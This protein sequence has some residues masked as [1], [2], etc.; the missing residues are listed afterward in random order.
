MK[1]YKV[2]MLGGSFNP[3]H[4][5]HVKSIIKAS[6]L[7]DELH[8]IIGDLP[9]RDVFP[10]QEKLIWFKTIFKDYNNIFFHTLTDTSKEKANYTLG[11]LPTT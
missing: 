6:E 7:C 9:N 2:G 1:T 10:I 8:I 5:G 4:N 11:E 3:I